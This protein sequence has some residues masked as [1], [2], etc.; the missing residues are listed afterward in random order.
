VTSAGPS[1]CLVCREPA[2]HRFVSLGAQDYWSC[3]RCDAVFLD[4]AQH[5]ARQDE[6]AQYLSHENDPGDPRYRTFLARLAVPLLQKLTAPARG[7]DY[8]CGPGPALAAML[9][10]AGHEMALYDPFFQPGRAPLSGTYDFIVC[11]EAAEHFHRPADEFDRLEAMLRPGGWLGIMTGFMT[12]DVPFADW[13]Y[14]KDPTHVVFYSESTLRFVADARGWSCEFPA[15]GIALMH[16]H[17][18]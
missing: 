16:K 10:E 4:P 6:L 18:A 5:P 14:R 15:P 2:P 1:S 11:T 7:L 8:G 13:Y 3:R 9:R 12:G 17:A